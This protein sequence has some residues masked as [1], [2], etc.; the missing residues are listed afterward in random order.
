MFYTQEYTLKTEFQIP[1]GK[2]VEAY[3]FMWED[4]LSHMLENRRLHSS[5]LE[6]LDFQWNHPE[7]I[8]WWYVK[9]NKTNNPMLATLLDMDMQVK[10]TQK[11][12]YQWTFLSQN[13]AA[14]SY[15]TTHLHELDWDAFC[16]NPA[17]LALEILES[18]PER[19]R[20]SSLC[21]NENPRAFALLRKNL[22]F[23][24]Y[25][26]WMYLSINPST[27]ALD[28][29][30]EYPEQIWWCA[31]S[32]NRHPEAYK[33][34]ETNLDKI[35]WDIVGKNIAATPLLRKH[36][37]RVQWCYLC[38]DANTPDHFQ[39]LRENLAQLDYICW[40]HL[41]RNTHALPLLM[42]FPDR[43]T[44]DVFDVHDTHRVTYHYDYPAILASKYLLHQE[45]HAWAGHPS[46]ISKWPGWQINTD[47]LEAMGALARTDSSPSSFSLSP[48]LYTS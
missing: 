47:L 33:L 16:E 14:A 42:E 40:V 27:A 10:R 13:P 43:V 2:L 34:M 7:K 37:A 12:T 45:Y 17:E 38:I 28:L 36:L 19:I 1:F 29:L 3:G 20:Y 15:L 22:S 23:L 44:I 5:K 4:A 46:R 9:L 32:N 11:K 26:D 8:D 31:F 21:R 41:S 25:K 39:F 30:Q 48:P 6:D 24:D 18:F 35:H